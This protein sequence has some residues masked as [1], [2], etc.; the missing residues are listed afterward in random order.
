MEKSNPVWKDLEIVK[1]TTKIYELIFTKDGVYQD[2]TDW[3]VYFTVK[4][5]AKD[6]DAN[7]KISKT[8]TSHDDPTN[9][10]TL[11]ELEPDDT[12]DL[13]DGNYYYSID[14]KDSSDQEGVLFTGRFRILKP[15][16]NLRE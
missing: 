1:N 7:A 14:F 3:K 9:G 16:R 12:V 15:I 11:I 13:D 4:L 8:I 10:K 5:E 2:I 6:S